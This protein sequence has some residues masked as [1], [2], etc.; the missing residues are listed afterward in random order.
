M[1]RPLTD[2]FYV[3]LFLDRRLKQ[4]RCFPIRPRWIWLGLQSVW[5]LT[6]ALAACL[7]AH[8]TGASWTHTK[9]YTAYDCTV[10]VKVEIQILKVKSKTLWKMETSAFLSKNVLGNMFHGK[11][12]I[13]LTLRKKIYLHDWCETV[14]NRDKFFEWNCRSQFAYLLVIHMYSYMTGYGWRSTSVCHSS[15]DVERVLLYHVPEQH[16][17]QQSGRKPHLFKRTLAFW[18]WEA[19]QMAIR[20]LAGLT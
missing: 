5:V 12:H 10:L 8:C 1:I 7:S 19:Q 13:C 14:L 15:A 4:T 16:Q 9:R 3:S 17:V 2:Y 18:W 20:E 6:Y 11:W